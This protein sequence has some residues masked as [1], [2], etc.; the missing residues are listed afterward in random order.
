MQKVVDFIREIQT[1]DR[2]AAFDEAAVKQGI[3]LR[4][5]SLLDW[6]PF[7]PD[8]IHPEEDPGEARVAFSLRN[9]NADKVFVAVHKGLKNPQKQQEL[10]VA[11]AARGGVKIAVLTDGIAWWFLLPLLGES[12]EEKTFCTVDMR[13]QQAKDAEQCFQDYLSK[14]NVVSGKAVKAAEDIYLTRQKDFLIKENL[15]RAWQQLMSEPGKWLGSMLAEMTKELC[16]YLPD[17]E[18]VE[19]FI[20]SA[21]D[22]KAELSGAGAPAKPAPSAQPYKKTSKAVDDYAGRSVTSFTLKGKK[23]DVKSWKAM[24]LKICELILPQHKEELDILLTL[25]GPD[26]EYFS[27]NPYEFLTSE[28]IPGTDIHVNV[29]LSASEVVNLSQ[30]ILALFGLNSGDL[31][32]ETK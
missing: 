20:A 16:G 5:L 18:T 17:K 32:F 19:A 26:K 11:S 24:L 28:Q 10:L 27:K 6:D 23:Y 21:V 22:F 2:Y 4:L 31:S 1:N 25:S 9:K 8:E 12:L 3:V 29:G 15:P 7:N 30:E 13:S 14:Q